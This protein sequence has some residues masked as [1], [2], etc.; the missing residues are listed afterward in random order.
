MTTGGLC[1]FSSHRCLTCP[2]GYFVSI[3]KA[4]SCTIC[5]GGYYGHEG[6]NACVVCPSGRYSA[7]YAHFKVVRKDGASACYYC[8]AGQ[9]AEAGSKFGCTYPTS[10]PTIGPSFSPSNAPT[11]A[12]SAIPTVKPTFAD[13]G[14]DMP[15]SGQAGQAGHVAFPDVAVGAPNGS[16]RRVLPSRVLL[17]L[18]DSRPRPLHQRVP[19]KMQRWNQHRI[20]HRIQHPGQQIPQPCAQLC[21]PRRFQ[22]GALPSGRRCRPPPHPPQKS[23]TG[24]LLHRH[25][26]AC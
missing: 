7:V 20:Q 23:R 1:A 14:A 8:P 17:S 16:L 11:F 12:P 19:P 21:L 3:S 4:S 5:P 6:S 10:K 26:Q 24:R 15:T 18:I 9:F 2:A 13:F 22:H 25:C